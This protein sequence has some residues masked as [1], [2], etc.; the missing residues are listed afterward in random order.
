M[1]TFLQ[2]CQPIGSGV[3]LIPL[4]DIETIGLIA[5]AMEVTR[6]L[7]DDLA[8][9]RTHKNQ[10]N[11]VRAVKMFCGTPPQNFKHCAMITDLTLYDKENQDAVMGEGVVILGEPE[12]QWLF[13]KTCEIAMQHMV[14]RAEKEMKGD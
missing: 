1:H 14:N 13:V 4:N 10:G 2:K 7:V 11:R 5:S 9:M 8:D 3:F 12:Y 6:E